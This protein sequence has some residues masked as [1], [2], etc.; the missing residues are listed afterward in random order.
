L[1]RQCWILPLAICFIMPVS[2][3]T[4]AVPGPQPPTLVP[5]NLDADLGNQAPP[6]ITLRGNS[7][8]YLQ[9]R[10]AALPLRFVLHHL[11]GHEQPGAIA[12]HVVDHKGSAV[13]DDTIEP[14][15]GADV[16]LQVSRPETF[17]LAI[18]A[19]QGQPWYSLQVV[20]NYYVIDA[21]QRAHFFQRMPPQYFYVPPGATS[22]RLLAALGDEHE[23]RATQL[24]A[25]VQVWLPGGEVALDE[26]LNARQGLER[27]FTLT[28]PEGA[29]GAV[30]SL[31]MGP[32]TNPE[33]SSGAE[34]YWLQL[35]DIPPYLSERANTLLRPAP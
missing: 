30:W 8:L 20:G 1:H 3:Q 27:T 31:Q 34:D 12:Y 33:T 11:G 28:V 17:G 18:E 16:V 22:F 10:D 23:K 19:K 25:R 4:A 21:S 29:A 7:L 2:A 24:S 35:M 32:A 13:L 9:I 26:V 15:H 5:V 14:S 6:T